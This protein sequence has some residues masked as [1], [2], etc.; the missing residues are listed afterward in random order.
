MSF[1]TNFFLLF[2]RF[3]R[4]QTSKGQIWCNWTSKYLLAEIFFS[5]S[6]D[7]NGTKVQTVML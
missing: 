4:Q 6:S 2:L 5:L 7:F 3:P 1:R